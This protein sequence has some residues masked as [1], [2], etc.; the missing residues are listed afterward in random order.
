MRYSIILTSLLVAAILL[1]ACLPWPSPQPATTA[2]DEARFIATHS[3]CAQAGQIMK[4]AFYNPNSST[5][6]I[7][8]EANKPGCNPACVVDLKAKT[9]TVNWRCT[10][11]AQPTSTP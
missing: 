3:E 7:Q 6:W 11:L 1:S 8:M 9:A 2:L 5:W 4:P 10:G